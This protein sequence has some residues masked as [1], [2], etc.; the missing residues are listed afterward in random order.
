MIS[1]LA[2]DQALANTGVV[3]YSNNKI[4]TITTLKTKKE[5]ELEE[6]IIKLYKDLETL[7]DENNVELVFLEKVYTPRGLPTSWHLLLQVEAV[8]KVNFRMKQ[9]ATCSISSGSRQKD[10]WKRMLNVTG[11]KKEMLKLCRQYIPKINE[12]EADALGIL[13][14]GLILKGDI[15]RDCQLQEFLFR[16][17]N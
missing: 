16:T 14:A 6:R 8:L 2:L 3:L 13:L 5:D 17:Y 1:I 9:V 11:D 15:P 10:S 12:H 4:E 7:I